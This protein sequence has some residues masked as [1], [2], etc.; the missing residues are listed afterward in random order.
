MVMSWLW[1]SMLPQISDTCMF[2]GCGKEIWDAI[3]QTYSKVHHTA[4]IYQ[5]KTKFF[6]TKQRNQ[7]ITEYSNYLQGL[8]QEIDHYQCIQMSCSQDIASLKQFIE[9]EHIYDFFASL[10]VNL[11]L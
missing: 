8:W 7:S 2:L 11:M 9:N 3:G 1:N 10:N 4:Q 6:V 5:I